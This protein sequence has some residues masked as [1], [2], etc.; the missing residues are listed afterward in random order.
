MFYIKIKPSVY[1]NEVDI[2]ERITLSAEKRLDSEG[3]EIFMPMEGATK[4]E[5]GETWVWTV[6][7]EDGCVIS[8]WVKKPKT[9]YYSE[10]YTTF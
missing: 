7:K 10:V 5:D 3:C 4:E 6:R 1:V 8:E 9:Y 2:H